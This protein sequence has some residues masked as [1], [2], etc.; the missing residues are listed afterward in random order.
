MFA[1]SCIGHLVF[2]SASAAIALAALFVTFLLDFFGMRYINSRLARTDSENYPN[3]RGEKVDSPS[4]SVGD[5]GDGE[6]LQRLEWPL[7][8]KQ[9]E[10]QVLVLE[11]GIIFH[12]IMIGVTLGASGGNGWTTLLIVIVFHQFFEGMA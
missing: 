9:T 5:S 3:S 11:A 2:E 1:N 10:W 7:A 12:S 4:G 8:Q 6:A